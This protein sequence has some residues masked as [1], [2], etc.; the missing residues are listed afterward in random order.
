MNEVA[1]LAAVAL[2]AVF[3]WAGVQKL[4]QPRAVAGYTRDLGVPFPAVTARLLPLVE[5]GVAAAL[6]T[7]PPGGAVLA[8]AALAAFSAVLARAVAAGAT[9]PCGC[10]GKASD[11][12]VSGVDLVRNA[13]LAAL[14]LAAL[15]SPRPATP[16][17]EAVV[18]VSALVVAGGV[19][20]ALARLRQQV[21]AVWSNR[22]AREGARP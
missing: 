22:A 15:T 19:L 17:L 3:A 13:L 14:A 18:T 6:V 8:L 4:R 21:G 5:L 12:P 2:A 1:Y 9:T 16:S 10:L 11:E 20:L 7:V